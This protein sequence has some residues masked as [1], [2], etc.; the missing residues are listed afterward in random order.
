MDNDNR[1]R[2][3]AWEGAGGRVGTTRFQQSAS[4]HSGVGEKASLK[5]LMRNI[6]ESNAGRV[7]VDEFFVPG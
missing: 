3:A 7:D 6:S 4:T 1:V 5:S 2:V